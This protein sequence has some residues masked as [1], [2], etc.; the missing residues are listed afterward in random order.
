MSQSRTPLVVVLTLLVLIAGG[1]FC[2]FR[3]V[4][5]NNQL[6]QQNNNMEEFNNKYRRVQS[7]H[8][9]GDF[10]GA[11]DGY[12][13]LLASA[14]DK[15]WDSKVKS[16]LAYNLFARNQ[17]DDRAQAIK[18]YKDIIADQS[19][20]ARTRAIVIMDLI[21]TLETQTSSFYREYFPEAPFK[22][23]LSNN[24]S[25]RYN[26][27][28]AMIKFS[29]YSD[30]VYPNSLA[31]YY[32]A[33]YEVTLLGNNDL[34]GGSSSEVV[35]KE[36]QQ[37]VKAADA[38]IGEVIYEPSRIAQQYFF[39]A[40]SLSYSG[41][42][43]KNISVDEG[44]KA[45]EMALVKSGPFVAGDYK[46]R[47]FDMNTRFFY[48]SYLLR[49]V[50]ETESNKTKIKLILAPYKT[51]ASDQTNYDAGIRSKYAALKS[52]PDDDYVKSYSIRLSKISPDL[53]EF[54]IN[55]GVISK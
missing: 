24:E 6:Q 21:S 43:L 5:Q 28:K 14:P 29:Q 44:S 7:A 26:M 8:S 49:V 52:A 13:A 39:R 30:Q 10:T 9:S 2:Y 20:P 27:V 19:V 40:I 15:I 32:I 47:Y 50:G 1:G 51:A 34:N 31:K 45:Y 41:S 18:I 16:L 38:L 54:L 42:I 22:D 23:F 37:Y 53:K 48:A 4:R 17:N 46:V 12:K 3:Y 55:V 36:I 11:I 25:D 35:A 33:N